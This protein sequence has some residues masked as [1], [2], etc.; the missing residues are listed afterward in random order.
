MRRSETSVQLLR[1]FQ[2]LNLEFDRELQSVQKHF[3]LS[4]EFLQEIEAAERKAILGDR[5]ERW[6]QRDIAG[7]HTT[8]HID[9]VTAKSL[10]KL[11]TRVEPGWLRAE[12]EK[13]YRL[14]D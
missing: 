3:G 2:A 1:E 11:L 8:D 4:E 6:W 13:L 14:G 9:D 5:E 7:M 12:A 10:D